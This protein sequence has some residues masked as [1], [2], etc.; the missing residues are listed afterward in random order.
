MPPDDLSMSRVVLPCPN[1]LSVDRILGEG[2]L[3]LMILSPAH[4][5]VKVSAL[6]H[7]IE[8]RHGSYATIDP[9]REVEALVRTAHEYLSDDIDTVVFLPLL[10]DRSC[11]FDGL[12]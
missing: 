10:A 7:R 6:V 4:H 11:L 1:H 3:D 12:N 8:V 9:V 5:G 2:L